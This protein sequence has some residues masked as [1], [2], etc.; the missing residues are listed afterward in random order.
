MADIDDKYTSEDKV[1]TK[2]KNIEEDTKIN[3]TDEDMEDR[4][5]DMK[6]TVLEYYIVLVTTV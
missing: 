1:D 4:E 2:D 3:D 5:E 6:N